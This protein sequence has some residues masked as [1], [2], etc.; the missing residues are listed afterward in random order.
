MLLNNV[1]HG[2]E[3]AKVPEDYELAN[4][5]DLPC[6]AFKSVCPA[7]ALELDRIA[8]CLMRNIVQPLDWNRKCL[9]LGIFTDTPHKFMASRTL[10]TGAG[11]LVMKLKPMGKADHAMVL[12]RVRPA[13]EILVSYWQPSPKCESYE[14]VVTHPSVGFWHRSTPFSDLTREQWLFPWSTA[15]PVDEPPKIA[16][17]RETVKKRCIEASLCTPSQKLSWFIMPAEERGKFFLRPPVLD[18]RELLPSAAR[19]NTV[20][21]PPELRP[22]K[23]RRLLARVTPDAYFEL[24]GGTGHT[25]ESFL[26]LIRQRLVAIQPAAMAPAANPVGPAMAPAPAPGGAPPGPDPE[27]VPVDPEAV[28]PL[29]HHDDEKY[30]PVGDEEPEVSS[31]RAEPPEIRYFLDA[32]ESTPHG[33]AESSQ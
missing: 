2:M 12:R 6:S 26:G 33:E 32:E 31:P 5:G 3:A 14:I 13:C 7:S 10:V 8:Q 4:A 20:L 18:G 15:Y 23:R 1:Y 16:D 19:G 22:E 17:V 29:G 28:A 30:S 9:M 11:E 24:D 21:R 25:F 27:I